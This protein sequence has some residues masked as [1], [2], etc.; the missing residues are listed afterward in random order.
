MGNYDI[1]VSPS[2]LADSPSERTELTYESP[3]QYKF[4]SRYTPYRRILDKDGSNYYHE[5]FN[6]T[7][8]NEGVT[9]QF[10][11][12]TVKQENRLDIIAV[13]Y[14]G[15]ATYWWIIAMA[16][17]VIDPFNIPVGTV[18]RIPQL[19]AIYLSKGVMSDG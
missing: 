7:S 16:N 10:F 3:R 15:F 1:P 19:S 12:V 11:T 2:Y 17:N 4:T 14:Y 9:D 6:Q 8:I 5:S 13:K 18:L